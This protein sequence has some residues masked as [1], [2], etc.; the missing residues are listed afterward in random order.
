VKVSALEFR[1]MTASDVDLARFASCF[2]ANG[3]PKDPRV[4][5]WQ[6]AENPVGRVY[7]D[8]AVDPAHEDRVGAIYA[9]FPVEMQIGSHRVVGVQSLDTLTDGNYRGQGLFTRLAA[10]VYDRCQED[11][12]ALVYGFPNGSSA[13]GFFGK[14]GWT[15]LDPVPYLFLPLGARYFL[16]RLGLSRRLSRW[17][18][19]RLPTR[20]PAPERTSDE[21]VAVI[22]ELDGEIDA[23]WDSFSQQVR[24][25]VVRDR[26]YLSWRL[27]RPGGGYKLLAFRRAGELRGLAITTCKD[28]HG[29]RVGYL[30]ELLHVPD[31]HRAGEILLSAAVDDLAQSGADVVLSWCLEHSPNR[32]TYRR[33]GFRTL[34]P[35]VWPVELHFGVRGLAAPPAAALGNRRNWYLSYLDSD[36]V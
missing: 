1:A 31:D 28:K 22:L 33:C 34:P 23:L 27:R 12:V 3:D 5:R 14:L 10:S 30:M 15:R 25:A 17:V 4:L 24:T 16:H 21:E 8:L 20:P 2:E 36:T 6:Y 26:R 7:T 29:G 18:P 32:T 19:D 35:A 11:G 13:P 9:T